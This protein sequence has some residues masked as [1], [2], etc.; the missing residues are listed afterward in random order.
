MTVNVSPSANININRARLTSSAGNVRARNRAPNSSRSASVSV[1]LVVF[2]A[3]YNA[4]ARGQIRSHFNCYRPLV[5]GRPPG[6]AR[7]GRKT[8]LRYVFLFGLLGCFSFG[9]GLIELFVG[10]RVVRDPGV[11]HV[12]D[13]TLAVADPIL[14]IVVPSIPGGVVVP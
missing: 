9:D 14:G 8:I 1:N 2:M 10:H 7:A 13:S 6:L 3:P 11:T 4:T 5:I 12:V